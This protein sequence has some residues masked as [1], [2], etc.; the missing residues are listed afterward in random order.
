MPAST[1]ASLVDCNKLFNIPIYQRLF[2]WGEEQIN[3]LLN[4]LFDAMS[5]ANPYYVGIVTVVE[6]DGKWDIVDGQQRLTFFSLWAAYLTRLSSTSP[7]YN[8][9]FTAKNELRISYVGRS[10]D[11]QDLILI[12]SGTRI[13]D[14]KNAN[15]KKFIACAEKFKM[16]KFL[17]D[18]DG[19]NEYSNYIYRGTSFLVSELPN[20]YRPKDLN[21]FFEKMNSTGRQLTQVEQ[22]K[23]K[24][25]PKYASL[26][27]MCLN[28]EER[29][30]VDNIRDDE[31]NAGEIFLNILNDTTTQAE[32]EKTQEN[33]ISSSQ[34][35][36]SPEVFLLHSLYLTAESGNDIPHDERK[37]LGTFRDHVG[38]DKKIQ[39]E[40]L[41]NTMIQYRKWLDENII[42]LK[43][44]DGDSYEYVF[45]R[46]TEK[47]DEVDDSSKNDDRKM[48]QFQ[49]MLY[50]SS[51]NW[52]QWVLDAYLHRSEFSLE[53]LKAQDD[54]RPD[55]SIPE[56]IADMSYGKINRYWFWKLD[57][58]L[59][60][61]QLSTPDIFS[62]YKLS[63]DEAEAGAI[64][65]Y[66]FRR[67]RSIEHLHPQTDGGQVE[68][69]KIKHS[70]G[71]LAMISS[72][73][74]SLQQNESIGVK[75]ARLRDTQIPQRRL[76]SIK[77]LLMFKLAG[78]EEKGWTIEKAIKHGKDMFQILGFNQRAI[79]EWER[80]QRGETPEA[81]Q[82][83]L[84]CLETQ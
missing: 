48:R 79:D 24:Y 27:D 30:V 59:W 6:N 45:R 1:P 46:D 38:C 13:E 35:I 65:N 14:V 31:N 42:Y 67:N 43:Q 83:T 72:S 82:A 58:I 22:I 2:V 32:D 5:S 71:N 60:E 20:N 19:F 50:V 52:Q 84:D 80:E 44:A 25:F 57:Y 54:S 77:M 18:D 76:E 11:Q 17:D 28:F 64:R 69:N 62:D 26:F 21:L 66:K 15:F 81:N 7:W 70:F 63:L 3:L 23:G 49:S 74:N 73:F 8:F 68:W 53:L 29:C 37:I 56:E 34:S 78:G 75:F 51:S 33:K 41:L 9:L 55:H 40:C 61:K 4:D 39:P 10:E 16:D 47:N 36:L 12:A